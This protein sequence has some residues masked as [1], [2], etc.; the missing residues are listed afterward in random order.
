MNIGNINDNLSTPGN[1]KY[2][3]FGTKQGEIEVHRDQYDRAA[4]IDRNGDGKLTD[5][6]IKD[7]MR[8]N[9]LIRGERYQPNEANLVRD[10][11]LTLQNKPLEQTGKYHSY[12]EVTAQLKSLA[13]KYP[14]KA[15]LISIAKTAE[16]RDVW[17]LKVTNKNTTAP[18]PTT[19]QQP[20]ESAGEE[21][22]L[23]PGKDRKQGP[24]HSVTPPHTSNEK[25]G[26]VITGLHHAREWIALEV[27]LY[28]A[29]TML[30]TCATD[31]AM[32]KRVDNAVTYF[33]PLV[34]PDGYE[35][36]RTK[37]PWW[38]KNREPVNPAPA[39]G[40]KEFEGER[41][42]GIG[43][44]L[45]RNYLDSR[46][47]NFHMYRPDGDTPQSVRDDDGA[48]DSPGSEQFR[49]L[50][51]AGTA[52]VSALQNLETHNN[53]KAAIDFHSYGK[54]ILFPYGHSYEK[55][56]NEAQ[57]VGIG[58]RMSEAIKG[59][60]PDHDYYEVVQSSG[61]YP[62]SGSSED[63]QHVNDI[64]GFTIELSTSFAPDEEEIA[65]TC[66][67]LFA[68]QMAL[69]DHVVENFAPQPQQGAPQNH[70]A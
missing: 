22:N 42:K 9:E 49:G 3:L 63:F 55:A 17:A 27:P 52:E 54:Q 8:Q 14:D 6:E 56:E 32:Q 18:A 61:L 64:L 70:T 68:G 15:E 45:N 4:K 24:A 1:I 57:L 43:V 69:V 26:V 46:P 40:P 48:S 35:Y 66:Q 37:D 36:A 20:K 19:P 51:G 59:A 34:N 13:E 38:R 23:S 47:E 28:A 10:F 60:T 41:G 44:D 29:T 5:A 7:Y 62:A 33:V 65:P 67:K 2:T 39:N 53:V 12:E 25:P 11:K 50:V 30:E 31:P 21:W 58:N 16:G